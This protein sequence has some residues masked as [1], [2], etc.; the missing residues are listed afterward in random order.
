MFFNCYSFIN[1]LQQLSF[2]STQSSHGTAGF[3]FSLS[4]NNDIEGPQGAFECVQQTG[5]KSLESLGVLPCKMRIQ[6]KE[7]VYETTRHRM[8]AVEENNKNKW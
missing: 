4:G 5:A 2:P 6:A 1:I 3:T 7:D 8:A